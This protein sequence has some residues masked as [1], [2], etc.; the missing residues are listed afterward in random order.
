MKENLKSQPPTTGYLLSLGHQACYHLP[1]NLPKE[2]LVALVFQKSLR[3]EEGKRVNGQS[4]KPVDRV[5]QWAGQVTPFAT[6]GPIWG[7]PGQ[8][9]GGGSS[10]SLQHSSVC[11]LPLASS[12]CDFQTAL[13][14]N[15]CRTQCSLA[16]KSWSL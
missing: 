15:A 11:S 8:R 10:H 9:R 2:E 5:E 13:T 4:P 12:P 16:R 6:N 7:M 3:N 14:S 1:A